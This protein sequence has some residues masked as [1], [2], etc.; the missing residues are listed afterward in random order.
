[1]VIY[2]AE[3]NKILCIYVHGSSDVAYYV[4]FFFFFHKYTVISK[5]KK[6][7]MKFTK[8]IRLSIIDIL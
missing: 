6:E 8:R 1:M 4:F 2:E 5:H 3:I 7:N